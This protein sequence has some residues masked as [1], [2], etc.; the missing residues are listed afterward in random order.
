MTEVGRRPSADAP[1]EVEPRRSPIV[2]S[3]QAAYAL[4]APE[5]VIAI[6][7]GILVV[8]VCL[9]IFL[10]ALVTDA[11]TWVPILLFFVLLTMTLPVCFWAAK[12][13]KRLRRLIIVALIL[14]LLMAGPRY[15]MTEGI[16]GGQSDAGRYHQAGGML[17]VNMKKGKFTIA[18]TDLDSFPR[19]TRVVG[20]ITGILYLVFGTTYFGGFLIFSWIAWIG[21][22]CFF[23]SFQV[24]FPNAPPYLA[25]WLIFL[26]PSMLFWPS[27]TGKDAL[28][29]GLI[30]V[31]TLGAS[32]VLSGSKT[33]IGILWM[34]LA[35]VAILN[36]RP[37]LLLIS[38]LAMVV[39]LLARPTGTVGR[40]GIAF[41]I[42]VLLLIVP[43]LISGLGRMDSVLGTT[44]GGTAN[45]NDSLESTVTRTGIG[46][47]AFAATPVRRPWDLPAA[48]V[49]VIYR[50]FV[51][52]ARSFAVLLSAAEGM[53]LIVLTI[54]AFRWIWNIFPVM[55]RS[56]FGAYCGGYIVGFVIA[57][58]NISNAGILSRQR[59]QL[60]PLLMILVAAAHDR[61]RLQQLEKA[62]EERAKL[63]A[64]LTANH[65][66]EQGLLVADPAAPARGA[67]AL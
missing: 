59:V 32:R 44:A 27:S 40:R 35:G 28:M 38:A 2:A 36:I 4:A 15:Y 67:R 34:V 18:G 52:E 50:P 60:Y 10:L 3:K 42:I 9:G 55:Y 31:F 16:Y 41:P 66:P 13:D 63:E 11:D 23:R 61:Y 22:L 37:H 12:G 65:A 57:F 6:V 64:T 39:S 43:V 48:T 30:G 54:I 19:N 33:V 46:G 47:S 62:E 29:V 53:L 7:G 58:S 45:L 49:T 51:F 21:L 1:R 26:L 5:S 17:V 24:A 25:A 56:N 8:A 14:K 20:Y